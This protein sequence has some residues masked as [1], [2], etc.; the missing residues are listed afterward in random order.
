MERLSVE[1]RDACHRLELLDST[2]QIPSPVPLVELLKHAA[3]AQSLSAG[4]T[5]LAAEFATHFGTSPSTKHLSD[6]LSQLVTA[7]TQTCTA[8]SLFAQTA[9]AS[10]SSA[11]DPGTSHADRRNWQMVIDHAT[12]R[13][14]LRR[15]SEAVGAAERHLQTHREMQRFLTEMRTPAAALPGPTSRTHP[16]P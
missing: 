15:A 10:A 9:H 11:P 5:L 8:S 14:E 6:A 3:T 16:R 4:T 12:G 13:R 2:G 1:L 7:V